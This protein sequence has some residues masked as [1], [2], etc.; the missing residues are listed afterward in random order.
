M[1]IIYV[2]GEGPSFVV[3]R[4]PK[5][6]LVLEDPC[7]SRRHL[8]FITVTYDVAAVEVC[9]TNGAVVGGT[10]VKKG[11]KGYVRTGDRI[12]IGDHDIVWIG[13]RENAGSMFINSVSGPS[14]PEPESVEIEGPPQRKIP[15][16][17]SLML[18]AG[19]ALTMAV[20]ILL[21][22]GRT[23]AVLS[24][25]FAAMWAAF[26]VLGRVRKLRTEEKRRRNSYITYLSSCEEEIRKRMKE[27]GA[28]LNNIYP[29]VAR[30]LKGGG[31]PFILWNRTVDDTGTLCV[32]LGIG[33][34]PNPVRIDIPKE[35]FAAIDDSLRELPANIRKKY[36]KLHSSPVLEHISDTSIPAFV[37]RND[38]DRQMLSSVILQLAVSYPP[39]QLKMAFCL[40]KDTMRY[41]MWALL[42]P[43]CTDPGTEP[44]EGETVTVIT[45]DIQLAY[46]AHA[47][48]RKVMIAV[49]SESALPDG[50]CTVINDRPDVRP[51]VIPRKL[52]FSYAGRLAGLWG[53]GARGE[54][55]PEKVPFG[56]LFEKGVLERIESNYE[57]NDITVSIAAPIGLGADGEKIYLDLHEKAAGPHGL[58]AGTTGSGKSE[59]LTTMIL[60]FSVNF[61]P[62]KLSFFLIDYKGGGMSN[63]FRDLPHLAGSISN[64]SG[65]D[66]QRAMTALRSE[67]IRRQ[68][69]FAAASVNNINDYTRLYDRKAVSEPLPH[70]LI[71]VDEFAELKKEEPEFMDSLISVSQVGRSLGMHLILAT[72]KPSGVIDDKIRSNSRFRIALRLVDRSDSM[73]MLQRPDAIS[74]KGCGRAYLQV[75]NNEVFECFQSGY[76]M[77]PVEEK[78]SAVRIYRDF[79]LDEEIPVCAEGDG[80]MEDD[81]TTWYALTLKRVI[82]TDAKR[83]VCKEARLWL[84]PLPEE[85]CDEKAYA[86]FD[87]P[88]MQKYEHALYD[89]EECGHV[90][91]A[92][93]SGSGKSEL[94]RTLI[95]RMASPAAVYIVDYGGGILKCLAGVPCCG[96]Y[97]GDDHPADTV[98]LTGFINRMLTKR[99][100]GTAKCHRIILILDDMPHIMNGA[101]PEAA[102]D[103]MRIL[104]LGKS[105]G[106]YV[107]ATSV[108]IPSGRIY[109]LFDT[110]FYMGN[111]DPYAVASFL[112]RA[113]RD[114]P[115]IRDCPGRGIGVKGGMALEFQSVRAGGAER[116]PGGI[117]AGK[118]PHVP[119]AP[120]L[121]ELMERSFAERH[122][123]GDT[124]DTDKGGETLPAGYD[125]KSG[126]L[127]LL[128]LRSVNCVL[129]TGK[130]Y[131]GKHTFLFN[132][133]IMAARAGIPC[134]RADTGEAVLAICRQCAG[135]CVVTV[136]SFTSLLRDFYS[137]PHSS[138][139]EDELASYLENPVMPL[140]GGTSHPVIAG[141]MENEARMLF[142]G[143]KVFEAMLSHPYGIN[144]GGCMDENRILDF[145]YLPFSITQMSQSR[146]FATVLKFDEKSYFGNVTIPGKIN[147][148][149]SQTV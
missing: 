149:N 93:R 11:Y 144:F 13:K 78:A 73:D 124:A 137:V 136:E 79:L 96:G 29:G 30:Y 106:I 119:D 114:L 60:S 9:G 141:I 2:S 28:A 64:L 123:F 47:D 140:A 135:L 19:P 53:A 15:E 68:E 88:Y 57:K 52:C 14:M 37:I 67:N 61:A 90:L 16:K 18:A 95:C 8:H 142:S 91:I 62:E 108:S 97:I 55:I 58:I 117:S 70:I 147:V 39:S 56:R 127:Y 126:E 122:L 59:L 42:L 139:E 74:I 5:S 31:D 32:R 35:R 84:P 86:V 107:V 111:D 130:P 3:G 22:A 50:I 72:Q 148:D 105:Y 41:Y 110:R 85:I 125:I 98:R 6:D 4:D 27:T 116:P 143:R 46:R 82:E 71:I 87:N 133:S 103:M 100:K 81:K 44:G 132:I 25:V 36:E 48:G 1:G 63:L 24:S 131:S 129:V 128:P 20:P 17:P 51:D 92:G 80:G 134:I 94:V 65:S 99:R 49:Y 69:I 115:L 23:I 34:V 83:G 26:N 40:R 45:D 43:H 120:S 113:M 138:R 121:E 104:T 76:A 145:S 77:G 146:C 75:G 38:K 89:P 7:I 101:D 54:N 21:G 33:A 10:H 109:D 118:Y 12:R 112:G 66:I 102:D